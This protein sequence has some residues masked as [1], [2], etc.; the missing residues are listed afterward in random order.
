[1][2]SHPC[3][4][5]CQVLHVNCSYYPHSEATVIVAILQTR[6]LRIKEL[7]HLPNNSQP[8]V[9]LR[10]KALKTAPKVHFIMY[11]TTPAIGLA[12]SYSKQTFPC[13]LIWFRCWSLFSL[14]STPIPLSQRLS[15]SSA[16]HDLLDCLSPSVWNEPTSPLFSQHL[17][18][19]LGLARCSTKVC[20]LTQE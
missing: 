6:K 7:S 8:W 4:V 14:N 11:H 16:V 20:L 17:A 5:L 12:N 9:G 1:M 2:N 15:R 13:S 3:S 10:A 19:C 18:Q